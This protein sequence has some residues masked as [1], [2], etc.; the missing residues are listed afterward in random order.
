MPP[1]Y[2][3]LTFD[4][5]PHP[6]STVPLLR[7]LQA[8]RARATFFICGEHAL[9]HPGLLRAQQAAQMWIGNHTFSHP[10]LTQLTEPAAYQEIARAQ[11]AIRQITGQPPTLFRP[12]YGDTDGR[13][14][15]GAAGLGLAEVLWT[16][17]SR[18]WAG[19]TSDEIVAAAATVQ[20]GGII[21]LH[22]GGYQATVDAVPH[23]L[24]GLAGRGLRPGRIGYQPAGDGRRHAVAMAP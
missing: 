1:G 13:V 14:R 10:R 22:D 19:A 2:V 5:G 21:L 3:A 17:D 11:Q 18:D 20:P 8:A 24:R 12:P 7:A 9:Q 16:V 4:D 15:A 6:G 23:I